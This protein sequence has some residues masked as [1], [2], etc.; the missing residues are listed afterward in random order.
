MIKSY[1]ENH[2]VFIGIPTLLEHMKYV[3]LAIP[4][5]H[6]MSKLVKAGERTVREITT[7]KDQ[8]HR[9]LGREFLYL[10][11]SIYKMLTP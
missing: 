6:P 4:Q 9:W 5:V 10:L 8:A 3:Y 11:S 7:K 1:F 2:N